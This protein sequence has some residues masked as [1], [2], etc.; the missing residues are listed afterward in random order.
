VAGV[1]QERYVT[2]YVSASSNFG[3]DGCFFRIIREGLDGL[4]DGKD[5]FEL[6]AEDVIFDY[7]ISVHGY[8]PRVKGRQNNIEPVPRSRRL[9]DAEQR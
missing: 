6:Q 4:V 9:H 8:Q 5:Y 7:V 1:T 2:K 3:A